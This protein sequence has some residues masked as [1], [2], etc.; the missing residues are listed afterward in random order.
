[1]AANLY[2][3]LIPPI[4]WHGVGHEYLIHLHMS[5][6]F[7]NVLM[8]VVDDLTRIAHFLPCIESVTIEEN[9]I[10]F[11]HGVDRLHRRLRV[12][13][14]HRDPKFVSG[15]RQS[16][17]RR[18]GTRLNMSSTRHPETDGLT[19]R[20]KNTLKHLLRWFCWYD[21]SKWT[22]MLPQVEVS[23]NAIRALGTEHTPFEANLGFSL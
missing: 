10:L 18:L 8:I 2:P 11:L 15:F 4:P 5:N 17:W 1:M 14:T 23:Y 6:G 7:D 16:L 13:V 21:L 12:L 20:F 9:A 19:E 22:D 3:I